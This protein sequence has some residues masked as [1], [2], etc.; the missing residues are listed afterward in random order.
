MNKAAVG[1]NPQHRERMANTNNI[2]SKNGSYILR[3]NKMLKIK[4]Y[5]AAVRETTQTVKEM[6]GSNKN[7]YQRGNGGRPSSAAKRENKT[8]LIPAKKLAPTLNAAAMSNVLKMRPNIAS[9]MI[10]VIAAIHATKREPAKAPIT[11]RLVKKVEYRSYFFDMSTWR[12]TPVESSSKD[13]GGP[14]KVPYST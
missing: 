1:H 2:L 8:A 13:F 5:A 9:P 10:G 12:S 3:K 11:T 7:L 4:Q 14:E 6:L